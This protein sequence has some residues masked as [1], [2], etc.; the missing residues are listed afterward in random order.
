VLNEVSHDLTDG[1]ESFKQI[2]YQANRRLRLRVRIEGDLARRAP[3]IAHRQRL[4][5]FTAPR[6]R[7]PAFEHARLKNVEFCFRHCPLQS[8]QQAVIIIGRIIN[9]IG[10]RDQ[11]VKQRTDL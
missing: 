6:L 4:A 3:Q 9:A 11:R 10:V 7:P 5:Q 8:E 1:S 2:E